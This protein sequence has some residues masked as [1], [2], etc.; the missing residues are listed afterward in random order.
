MGDLLLEENRRAGARHLPL[1]FVTAKVHGSRT[2]KHNLMTTNEIKMVSFR[3]T[4]K[5]SEI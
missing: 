3:C 4:I 1:P 2:L 5:L